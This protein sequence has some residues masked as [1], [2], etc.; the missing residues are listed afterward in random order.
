MPNSWKKNCLRGTIS[1]YERKGASRHHMAMHGH[2][3]QSTCNM[4]SRHSDFAVRKRSFQQECTNKFLFDTETLL[5]KR[6]DPCKEASH[7]QYNLQC[8]NNVLKDSS[9]RIVDHSRVS[10]LFDH[11]HDDTFFGDD[12]DS[13]ALSDDSEEAPDSFSP[14]SFS[15]TFENFPV[16]DS[17]DREQY[18]FV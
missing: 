5:H 18:V 15:L 1:R 17:S 13:D 12:F 8:R 14:D 10:T 7:L 16:L 3:G 9:G 2:A 6:N 11:I 4:C